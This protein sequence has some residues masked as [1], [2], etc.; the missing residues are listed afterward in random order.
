MTVGVLGVGRMGLPVARRFLAAGRDVL[1]VDPDPVRVGLAV[2]AGARR[3]TPD[4]VA[5]QVDVLVTVLPGAD[6]VPAVT[7]TLEHLR[8]GS[9]WL[10]LTS[11]DPRTTNA[12]AGRLDAGVV[13]AAMGG[14]PA[15]AR[16]GSLDLFV[17]GPEPD[18]QQVLPLLQ[19][20]SGN[21][22]SMRH[23]GAQPGAGQLV[24]LLANLLW[25]NQSLA[26]TESLLLARAA[27]LDVRGVREALAGS[28]GD[29]EFL[30]R[31][32]DHLLRGD[33]L[34]HFGVD[35]V[36]EEL[37][38]LAEVA[39]EAGTP[40][41]VGRLVTRLHHETLERFGPVDG[42]LLAARLLEERGGGPLHEGS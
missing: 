25:F 37:D 11:A 4:A 12:I 36:V 27:G 23:V 14:G 35:R 24:K 10:D 3:S 33:Y 32:V 42:E 31:H 30:R 15:D 38:V 5:G 21:G 9:V 8:P 34:R 6:E 17:G 39:R 2:A 26:V 1:A 13:G 28:A 41:D 16:E 18:V 29:S 7:P 19:D 20:L 22:G 40:Y